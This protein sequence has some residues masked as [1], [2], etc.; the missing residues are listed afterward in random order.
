[1]GQNPEIVDEIWPEV[2]PVGRTGRL[3][4]TVARLNTNTVEWSR[5]TTRELISSGETIMI[6]NDF[7]SGLRKYEV[8]VRTNVDRVTYM[9]VVRR[10]LQQDA[11]VYQC[12]VRI[13]SVSP[14]QWPKKLGTISVKNV[15]A[16][17]YTTYYCV[18]VNNFG[19][20]N[21]TIVLF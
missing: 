7:M 8:Q 9:L 1:F 15:Q 18:A 4:C 13:Q 3:N 19:S 21:S 17:D 10:M 16:N 20:A 14:Q 6:K 12:Q 11:G 5:I 2:Q